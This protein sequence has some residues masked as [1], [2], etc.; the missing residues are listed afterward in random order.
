MASL[1]RYEEEYKCRQAQVRRFNAKLEKAQEKYLKSQKD[2]HAK[3]IQRLSKVGHPTS[4]IAFYCV[5]I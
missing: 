1:R 2:R 3:L 5:Q 4:M